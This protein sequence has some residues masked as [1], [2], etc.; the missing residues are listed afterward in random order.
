LAGSGPGGAVRAADLDRAPDTRADVPRVPK[1]QRRQ[2][3]ARQATAALMAKSK[4]EIPHYYL[5]TTVE[6][7]AALAWMHEHNATRTPDQ[8]IL[9][10]ALTLRSIA[11]AA[12][13]HPA[14]NGFWV[15]GDLQASAAVHL[16]L[17]VSLRGG[18]LIVATIRDAGELG[19]DDLMRTI[20][21][22][23]SRARAG[24]LRSSEMSAPTITVTNLGDQ[25]VEEVFGVTYPPQV[26]L[27]GCGR[28]VERPWASGGLLGV[29]PVMRLT[30]SADHR[31][32]DGHQ[33]ARFLASIDHLLQKPEAL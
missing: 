5:A 27:V 20:G 18:G 10:A 24:T 16:G 15:E 2:T 14:M 23:T 4:R 1:T 12:G 13:E 29:K 7:D 17:A 32:S 9:P 31:A 25:G 21:D 11:L 28:I 22:I 19:I 8:R 33:G 6:L 3:A 26:A 30:L